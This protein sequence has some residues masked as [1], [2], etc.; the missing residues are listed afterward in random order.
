MWFAA[1][2]DYQNN[3]WFVVFADKLLKADPAT[4]SLIKSSPFGNKP[5][6]YVRA[7]LYEY[8]FTTPQE[9]KR[10]GA[11]WTRKLVGTYLPPVQRANLETPDLIRSLPGLAN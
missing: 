2:S 5:P 9:R 7:L 4:L 8:H 10:T 1:M 3:P 6:A 11:W